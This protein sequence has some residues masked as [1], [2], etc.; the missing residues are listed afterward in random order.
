MDNISDLSSDSAPEERTFSQAKSKK[1]KI[2][3]LKNKIQ[4]KPQIKSRI[5]S[6]L[7]NLIEE[8]L[9][10]Q[11]LKKISKTLDFI[12]TK[13]INMETPSKKIKENEPLAKKTKIIDN[14]IKLVYCPKQH[15]PIYKVNEAEI[16]QRKKYFFDEKK[17][18]SLKEIIS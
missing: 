6:H 2:P 14:K 7:K 1:S 17:R 8:K 13:K 3:L 11:N 5:A 18:V 12:D 15:M 4:K 16:L 9:P 10:E